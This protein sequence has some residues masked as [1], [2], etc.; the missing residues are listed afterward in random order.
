[1][2]SDYDQ[3]I[4]IHAWEEDKS[5]LD[6]DDDL[7]E[8][9]ITVGDLLVAGG[10]AEVELAID[11]KD[12]GAFITV[13]CQV[14]SLTSDGIS[15]FDSDLC[16]GLNKLCGCV[17]IIITK[18]FDI[19]LKVDKAATFVKVSFEKQEFYTSV[20]TDYPGLDALNPCYDASFMVPLTQ[21]MIG[22]SSNVA[23][24]IEFNL[25]N[26][27]DTILG[28]TTVTLADLAKAPKMAIQEKRRIGRG[29]A[30]IE[31]RVTMYGIDT[32]NMVVPTTT[33]EPDALLPPAAEVSVR[34][35]LEPT[36]SMEF[37][38]EPGVMGTVR[39]TAVRGRGFKVQKKKF[40]K[41]DIPDVYLKMKFGHNKQKWKTS[42]VKDNVAPIWGESTTFALNDN[43]EILAID[44]Y[45]EDKGVGDSDD[46][47]GSAQVSVS[48]LLLAAKETELPLSITKFGKPQSTGAFITVD[49]DVI[50]V[51]LDTSFATN[52]SLG[53]SSSGSIGEV[54]IE[55]GQG[56]LVFG[57]RDWNA[58]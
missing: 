11:E 42:T 21:E 56:S 47:L 48:E 52:S 50:G 24:V 27:V 1:M 43:D 49:C 19:P 6:P 41:N 10:K 3:C 14:L 22:S 54:S 38:P 17:A 32:S 2:L 25:M 44:A 53:M 8:A 4:K 12:S 45:D 40:K 18:A 31:F 39:I 23:G 15:S 13:A 33:V 30:S 26:G 34:P 9:E 46:Y 57:S 55:S 51:E 16:R 28:T 58:S 7:G 36:D 37:G 5:P 20:I 29:G 35:R